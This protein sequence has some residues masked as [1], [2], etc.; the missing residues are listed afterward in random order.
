VVLTLTALSN[1]LR[2]SCLFPFNGMHV[3]LPTCLLTFTYLYGM[4]SSLYTP[5]AFVL[6]ET[7]FSVTINLRPY[8]ACHQVMGPRFH[9]LIM[10]RAR[11]AYG[12]HWTDRKSDQWS[13]S[14]GR[15]GPCRLLAVLSLI[16]FS[17][18]FS[19][20]SASK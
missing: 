15:V 20:S 10:M 9:L 18:A 2:P 4:Q 7:L 14:D 6:V 19:H 17:A 13:L 8:C 1:F 11:L 16:S 5:S 12:R 3:L